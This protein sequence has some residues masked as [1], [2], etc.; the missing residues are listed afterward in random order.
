[1]GNIVKLVFQ[2]VATGN[3]LSKMYGEVKGLAAAMPGLTKATMILGQAFG[4]VGASVGRMAT[5]L[6]Q[7]GIWGVAAEGARLLIDKLGLFKDRTEEAKKQLDDL[8]TATEKYHAAILQNSEKALAKIDAET[9]RR[10]AQ[11]D[12]THRMIKAELEL[13]RAR[14]V[15]TGDTG[16][17]ESIGH[18][19]EQRG[20]EATMEKAVASSNAAGA[21]SREADAGL[22]TARKAWQEAQRELTRAKKALAAASMPIKTTQI[23]QSSAGAFAMTNT[24]HRDTT[25]EQTA[26]KAAKDRLAIAEK[27]LE[28]ARKTA[29]EERIRYQQARDEVKALAKEQEAAAATKAAAEAEDRRKKAVQVKQ[30]LTAHASKSVNAASDADWNSRFSKASDEQKIAMLKEIEAHEKA[31]MEAAEK[32]LETVTKPVTVPV[33]QPAPV[34]VTANGPKPV[35]VPVEQP[36][37]VS[38]TANGPKP[39]EVKDIIARAEKAQAAMIA[40]R[41]KREELEAAKAAKDEQAAKKK[42]LEALKE[43]ADATRE[44]IQ[45]EREAHAEAMRRLAEARAAVPATIDVL[46]NAARMDQAGDLRNKR[47]ADI[48]DERFNDRFTKLLTSGKIQKDANGNWKMDGRASNLDKAVLDRLNA[49]EKVKRAEAE[50]AKERKRL[51]KMEGYL[52]TISETIKTATEI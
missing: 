6:L 40:A 24:V 12:I 13:Q 46:G 15:A 3:G 10:N 23:M 22:D 11:L 37:P 38:V 7:G 2:T 34:S 42:S 16:K 28:T 31:V 8:K 36:A 18:E 39:Q 19:I 47:Q 50:A 9:K 44:H 1:M 49:N 51:E 48:T 14:A 45:Q 29:A 52:K 17:A 25:N 41:T 27:T 21:R 5:M 30:D 35:R 32:D 43:K 26:V 33:E 20:K 4:S